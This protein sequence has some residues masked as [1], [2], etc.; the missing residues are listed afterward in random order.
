MSTLE[1]KPIADTYKD[2]LQ[3]S[4]NNSGADITLLPVEDGEGTQTAL[5]LSTNMIG[6][7]GHIIPDSNAAYDI[8]SADYKVRHLFLSDNSLKFV[9]SG[10]VEYSLGVVGAKLQYQGEDILQAVS[11][12]YG[13]LHTI[14][15]ILYAIYYTLY[16]ML[17]VLYAAYY[18]LHTT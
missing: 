16:T 7:A 12:I 13:I 6:I 11:H 3:I 4:N 9:D 14:Y 10:D 17:Y 18:V 5:S 8:G 15:C 1:G 2:L